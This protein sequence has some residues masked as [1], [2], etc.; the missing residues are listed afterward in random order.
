[1]V[2]SLDH[3]S[4]E[5]STFRVPYEELNRKYRNGHKNIEK[6]TTKIGKI[7][8]S[9]RQKLSESQEPIPVDSI[10]KAYNSLCQNVE[11]AEKVFGEA[12][13]NGIRQMD[14][15]LHRLNVLEQDES[16]DPDNDMLGDLK[17]NRL[18]AARYSIE[19]L[20]LCG[21]LETAKQMA[22]SFGL[23]KMV[24]SEVYEEWRMVET[25]LL[26][27]N[28]KPC[29]D[30][31]DTHRSKLKRND[32]QLEIVI[33][34]QDI[35]DMVLAGKRVQAMEYVRKFITPFAKTLP[36]VDIKLIMSII[37]IAPCLSE[38]PN[39][40]SQIHNYEEFLSDDRWE[41]CV[42]TF[43]T[44]VYRTYQ[45]TDQSAFSICLQAGIAAHKTPS[46]K[47]D[48][49]PAKEVDCYVCNE[50]VWRLA[51]GLPNAHVT[52]SRILCSM[53]GEPCNETNIPYLLPSGHVYG[54]SAIDQLRR[55]DDVV[56]PETGSLVPIEECQRLFFL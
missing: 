10:K 8:A 17:H 53:T 35:I 46:C 25:A 5:Y 50:T 55:G 18:R 48:P 9:I 26:A 15:F 1:M 45:L 31:I 21:H 37:A 34:R 32:S 54:Q 44:E 36:S 42:K 6:V 56:C 7:G 52:V 14:K 4:L 39:S 22:K 29:L 3:A 20:L 47:C 40:N 13:E 27:G 30:W 43:Q 11:E 49:R 28:T 19:Y 33:R 12:S 38:I 23:E 51:D 41:K 16:V 2:K 24:D